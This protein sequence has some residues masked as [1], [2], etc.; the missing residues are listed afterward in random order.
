MADQ[1]LHRN[2]LKEQHKIDYYNKTDQKTIILTITPERTEIQAFPM[3]R[4]LLLLLLP[5]FSSA[6]PTAVDTLHAGKI[7]LRRTAQTQ[8]QTLNKGSIFCRKQAI[9]KR[10]SK[11]RLD[12]ASRHHTLNGQLNRVIHFH[13]HR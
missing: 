7:N 10:R 8:T 11:S 5:H 2:P 9:K 12:Q 1:N 4:P 6:D 3:Q 13:V